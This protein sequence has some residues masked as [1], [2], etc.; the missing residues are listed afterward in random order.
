MGLI[1][2]RRSRSEQRLQ[3]A[4]DL[5][6]APGGGLATAALRVVGVVAPSPSMD[7]RYE[8][9]LVTGVLQFD[10]LP[11]VEV[12]NLYLIAPS[13]K[14]PRA[15]DELPAL[16]NLPAL[17]ANRAGCVK[18]LWHLLPPRH[19]LDAT[20]AGALAADLRGEA[21]P[22]P[23]DRRYRVPVIGSDPTRP[24]PG[25]PGGGTTVA[26]ANAL[27]SAGEPA[28]AEVTAAVDVQPPRLLRAA[29]PP[30]GAVD[31][32]LRV[33][34]ATGEP[35]AVTTRVAFSAR[36]RRDYVAQVGATLPVRIDP[37]H[38]DRVAIDTV[39]LGFS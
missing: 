21:A 16:V 17:G 1:S 11:A 9:C 19:E 39:E 25:S 20:E 31:L 3:Q 33:I 15:G 13:L 35:Y 36:A 38:R 8:S 10:L 34:P 22:A 18:V 4:A 28:V 12:E 27:V 24:L 29:A 6:F 23:A 7:A 5:A 32:T 37:A 30:G 2:W 26:Q 14:W